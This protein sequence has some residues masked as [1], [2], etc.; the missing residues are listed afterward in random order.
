MLEACR[1]VNI[2]LKDPFDIP[3][4]FYPAYK[5]FSSVIDL[6]G[7]CI[8]GNAKS[9]GNTENI[10]AGFQWLA[11][12]AIIL[13]SKIP[14]KHILIETSLARYSLSDLIMLR[15]FTTR[16]QATT[17]QEIPDFDYSI[18]EPIS[19]ILAPAMESYWSSL[20]NS[21]LLCNS[22]AQANIKPYRNRPIFDCLLSFRADACGR[23][24]SIRDAFA[25]Y[26]WTF[27]DPIRFLSNTD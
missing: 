3:S 20:I 18:L 26:D 2:L 7:R 12:P 1:S 17:T 13:Y 8:W 6:L 21:E 5:I 23:Y 14:Q 24:P 27:K 19:K 4:T 15:H 10:L 16:G 9:I 11:A 25:K 22:L